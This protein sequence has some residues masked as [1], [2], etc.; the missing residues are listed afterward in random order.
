[1]ITATI[2]NNELI[3]DGEPIVDEVY[4]GFCCKEFDWTVVLIYPE[5]DSMYGNCANPA[6]VQG[7]D[8]EADQY[9]GTSHWGIEIFALELAERG[10]NK[11]PCPSCT[12]RGPQW[13][14]NHYCVYCKHTYQPGS[15]NYAW[16]WRVVPWE[17]WLEDGKITE[18]EL[19]ASELLGTP[20]DDLLSA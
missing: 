6:C 8:G 17:W 9:Q 5:L 12:W 10:L 7:V 19:P 18:D 14:E 16:I 1:M 11:L 3:Y 2:K 13:L 20:L 15:D 4:P